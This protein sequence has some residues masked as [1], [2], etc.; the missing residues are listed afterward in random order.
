MATSSMRGTRTRGAPETVNKWTLADAHAKKEG[1]RRTMFFVEAKK[2]AGPPAGRVKAG[3]EKLGPVVEWAASSSYQGEWSGDKR[4]GFGTM[5]Y[6]SGDKYEGDWADGKRHGRGTLWVKRDG[7]LVKRYAGDWVAGKWDGA[8]SLFYENGD[9]Y[10]GQFVAGR[11]HGQ[12]TH[13]F[14]NGDVYEGE[15]VDNQRTGVG[16]LTLKNGD[17]YEGHWKADKKH[18]PGRFFFQRTRKLYEGEWVDDVAKCGVFSEI[19]PDEEDDLSPAAPKSTAGFGPTATAA[20][21][22]GARED[23]FDLPAVRG[24][25]RGFI[26]FE[27]KAGGGKAM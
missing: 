24:C 8:G 25:E 26:E 14:A 15:W 18:G 11:R 23:D 2:R 17:V 4:S 16:V 3:G 1:P 22:V 21:A 19:A 20:A 5:T 6:P 27:G 9:R 13:V 12:G 7:T 10:E